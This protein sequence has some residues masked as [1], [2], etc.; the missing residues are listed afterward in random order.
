MASGTK[1]TLIPTTFYD[2]AERGRRGF[3]WL[4]PV[5]VLVLYL[6][7][8]VAFIWLQQLHNDSFMFVTID[9]ETRQQRFLMVVAALSLVIIFSLL[10]LWRYTRFRTRAEA[11]LIAETGFRRAME[12][13]MSTGMRVFD[14]QGRI[15]YV[16][17]AFCRMR[18]EEH[19]SELQSRP[20]LVCRLLLEKKN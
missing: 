10:A 12:N 11:A 4:T 6:C 17:P 9:Q 20:H 1:K 2:Q 7:V 14:M 8:M 18:S 16:N 5:I 15:A 3:Y 19:T 13:S